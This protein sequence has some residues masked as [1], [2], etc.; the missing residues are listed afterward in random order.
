MNSTSARP[1]DSLSV[2]TGDLRIPRELIWTISAFVLLS[3]LTWKAVSG[4]TRYSY[5]RHLPHIILLSHVA[6]GFAEVL[7]Y[8]IPL[9]R[10]GTAP[11]PDRL[12]L[13][14]CV[15][16]SLSSIVLNASTWRVKTGQ[17]DL[18]RATFNVMILQRLLA[19]G[20]AYYTGSLVW[21]NASIKLLNS[22]IWARIIVVYLSNYIAGF[23]NYGSRYTVGIVGA[24]VMG[25]WEG[26]YPHGMIMYF[27]LGSAFLWLDKYY[28]GKHQ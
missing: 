19:G 16:H 17:H 8:Y 7:A 6:S 24:E 27:V 11:P 25:L 2:L 23:P 9:Y 14:T 5:I 28:S 3:P 15:C 4:K 1:L 21:H 10:F 20:I 22:Y 12:F 18:V 26:D 13:A